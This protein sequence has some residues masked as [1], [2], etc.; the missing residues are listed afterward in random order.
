MAATSENRQYSS[1]EWLNENMHRNYPIMDDV[2]PVSID[3]SML[4]STVLVDLSLS[5]VG[6]GINRN[7]FYVS[8]VHRL[9]TGI[10]VVIS[11]M[12]DKTPIPCAMTPVIP[13]T[14]HSGLSVAERTFSL[15]PIDKSN[16]EI[17]SNLTELEKSLSTVSGLV[18]IGSC[19][20]M[21]NSG[22]YQLSYASGK[23]MPTLVHVYSMGL[24]RIN[25]INA[26]G[27][28]IASWTDDFTLQAGDGI[29]FST[30][31]DNVLVISRTATAA[32]TEAEYQNI[33]QVVAK[34]K[35]LIGTPITSINGALPSGGDISIIGGDCTKVDSVGA[36]IVI[37]NPCS[38]PCC[39]SSDI[40]DVAA[41]LQSL[42]DAKTRLM[43][44]YTAI[45]TNINAI[46]SRLS[47]LIAS[48]G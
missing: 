16:T 12:N 9:G 5:C 13:I 40:S 18:I 37:S 7:G 42:E 41:A 46:Q 14:I 45:T 4:P 48:R 1:L 19:I 22:T 23:I 24:E 15:F 38:V 3:G 32:E 34:L 43:N 25:F 26:D 10:Q 27:T 6:A 2:I 35:E 8:H 30:D 20:D 47:S 28:P 31:G 11:Y 44:Y 29:D 17:Q 36:G 33:N 39:S 21:M